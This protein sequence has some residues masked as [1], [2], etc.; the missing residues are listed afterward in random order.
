VCKIIALGQTDAEEAALLWASDNGIETNKVDRWTNTSHAFTPT[1]PTGR[2]IGRQTAWLLENVLQSDGT[3]LL[4]LKGSL[5][6]E[7]SKAIEFLGAYKKPFLH[8]WSSSF[9][10]GLARP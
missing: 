2:A 8:L 6:S 10:G 9:H 1:R 4:T 5:G 3:L 7:Q